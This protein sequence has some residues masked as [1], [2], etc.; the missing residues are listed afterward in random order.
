M[1][2]GREMIELQVRRGCD[3]CEV[4]N[5]AQVTHTG[6]GLEIADTHVVVLRRSAS[7]YAI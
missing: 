1:K 2:I 3:S 4:K 7:D 6:P 5:V